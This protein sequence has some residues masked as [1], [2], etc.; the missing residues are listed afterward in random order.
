MSLIMAIS[1]CKEKEAYLNGNI[2]FYDDFAGTDTLYGTKIEFADDMQAGLMTVYDSI[3]LFWHP[4]YKDYNVLMCNINS[5]KNMGFLC[6]KGNGPEEFGEFAYSMQFVVD[7]NGTKIWVDDM[8]KDKMSLLNLSESIKEGTTIIDSIVDKK[9][10]EEFFN[11][12]HTFMLDNNMMLVKNQS[13]GRISFGTDDSDTYDYL[14]EAYRIYKGQEKLKEFKLYNKS[15]INPNYKSQSFSILSTCDRIKPDKS[16]VAMS[17]EKLPQ[18]NILDINTGVLSGF[19]KSNSIDYKDLTTL[20]Q[21]EQKIYYTTG[22]EVDNH[23][24][25]AMY[26]NKFIEDD[27][28]YFTKEIHVFDWESKAVKRLI[29]EQ[30]FYI[31]TLDSKNKK[32]YLI[33]G[34]E[35][36][37]CY[38]IA[39]LYK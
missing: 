31:M 2:S 28:Y 24:I 15:L 32:L 35:E 3:M 4:N 7:N 5:G 20:T 26:A 13:G 39:Y 21:E 9:G 17:M 6:R 19:R 12:S 11:I 27:S 37:Y 22:I 33:N 16:K 30:E 23:Y 1:S 10:K 8:L 18:I 38:D 14:P 36:V 34:R 25:F 29:F